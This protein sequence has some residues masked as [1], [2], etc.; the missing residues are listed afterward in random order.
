MFYYSVDR[1]EGNKAVLEGDDEKR[2]TA[3]VSLLPQGT[4]ECDVLVRNEDGTFIKDD[5]EKERRQKLIEALL[6]KV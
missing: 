6:G 2:I 4:Q 5:E 1:I 3:D